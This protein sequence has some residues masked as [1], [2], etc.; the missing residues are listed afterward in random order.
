MELAREMLSALKRHKKRIDKIL[1][2]NRKARKCYE[3]YENGIEI[4]VGSRTAMAIYIDWLDEATLTYD[5][6]LPYLRFYHKAYH[7]YGGTYE[8]ECLI[9]WE[10]NII[11]SEQV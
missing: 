11:F 4:L 6:S 9:D 8:E 3:I 5:P 10:G 1:S 7:P 2:S